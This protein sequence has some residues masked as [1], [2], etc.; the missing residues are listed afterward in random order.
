M[1]FVLIYMEFSAITLALFLRCICSKHYP[2]TSLQFFFT[3]ELTEKV[4]LK[5]ACTQEFSSL[6][7]VKTEMT[8][9]KYWQ[10]SNAVL[11][12]FLMFGEKDPKILPQLSGKGSVV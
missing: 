9:S 8:M 6:L 10:L 4:K 5:D 11:Q 3:L 2:F 12:Y 1:K 7:T